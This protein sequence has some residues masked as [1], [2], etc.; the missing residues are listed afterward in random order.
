MSSTSTDG[1]TRTRP[2]RRLLLGTVGVLLVMAAGLTTANAVRGPQ[3]SR[4]GSARTGRSADLVDLVNGAVRTE[5]IRMAPGESMEELLPRPTGHPPLVVVET[6]TADGTDDVLA[7]VS[8]GS[9]QQI[10]GTDHP[11]ISL[12]R[13]CGSPNG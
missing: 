4:A 11:P 5:P 12:T 2:F 8:G 13:L 3:V 1:A 7:R 10:R 6:S 9:T